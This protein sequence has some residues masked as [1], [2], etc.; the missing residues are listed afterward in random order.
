[1]TGQGLNKSVISRMVPKGLYGHCC[2]SDGQA[3]GWDR[4]FGLT[5]FDEVDVRFGF[6]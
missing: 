2:V 5:I 6:L 3:L 1:M 4:Y